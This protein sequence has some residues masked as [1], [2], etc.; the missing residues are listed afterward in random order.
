MAIELDEGDAGRRV[1]V[2]VGERATLRHPEAPTTGYRWVAGYDDTR[3]RLVEDRFDG[4]D[5]PHGA[6]GERVLVVEALR[7]GSAT[8]TL[9][10]QRA[11]GS[12]EPAR[13]L[14]V[15]LDV[16]E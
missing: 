12:G 4:A 9:R 11:W 13:T 8:L 3:L 16:R 15:E 1:G 5:E 14:S 7:G 6:G 10:K 2:R